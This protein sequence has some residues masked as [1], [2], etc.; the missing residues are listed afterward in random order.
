[1]RE[2][3]ATTFVGGAPLSPMAILSRLVAAFVLGWVVS[4]IYG[5]TT[6]GADGGASLPT[7]LVLLC[8]LI[9]M[10]T[11]VI[12]DNVARAFSLV[13]ALSIV[14]FRT[15][16]RDT[17]DTAFVIFAVAVGMATGSQNLWVAL[18]GLAVGGSAAFAM[19]FLN[20]NGGNGG[21]SGAEPDL[22]LRVRAAL[23]TELERVLGGSLGDFAE[24]HRMTSIGTAKQGTSIEAGYELKLRSGR[25]AEELLRELNRIEGMQ[26]VRLVRK[27]Y[28][29]S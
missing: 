9:A 26:E 23:G 11:Q 4:W 25:T 7:T 12:G 2:F 20:R 28:E 22:A 29:E 19:S 14:R 24:A 6:K 3:L 5:R 27:G 16:V 8:V 13:G 10:V 18:I 15:V 1:M 17:R 21:G